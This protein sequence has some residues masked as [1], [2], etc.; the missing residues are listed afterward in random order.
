MIID[1][2][3]KGEKRKIE[4][5]CIFEGK[6][7]FNI[8][9]LRDETDYNYHVSEVE[10]LIG[11]FEIKAESSPQVSGGVCRPRGVDLCCPTT[12]GAPSPLGGQGAC[13]PPH[14]CPNAPSRGPALRPWGPPGLQESEQ[15]AD[16][17]PPR[18]DYPES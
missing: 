2:V 8:I 6:L 12:W 17:C 13:P 16:K 9:T 14:C 11:L 5:E 4:L 18:L 15:P 7:E 1:L 3:K 10:F